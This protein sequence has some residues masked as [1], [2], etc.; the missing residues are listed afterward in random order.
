MLGSET[1]TMIVEYI[2]RS[3]SVFFLFVSIWKDNHA[4][5]GTPKCTDREGSTQLVIVIEACSER[6]PRSLKPS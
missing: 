2:G 6:A 1:T 5:R 3:K 4:V